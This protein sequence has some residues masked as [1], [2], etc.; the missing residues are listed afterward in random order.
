MPVARREAEIVWEG[1]LARGVG[2]LTSASGALEKLAVTWAS[3]TERAAG[4]TSPEE[5]L[6][7]AHASCFAMALALVLGENKTP[8]ERLGVSAA[9]TLDEVEG[10]PRVTTVELS[11]R[12]QVPGLDAAALERMVGLAADLCP[13]SNA[14]R[15]NVK[16]N[17]RSELVPTVAS[18]TP[19]PGESARPAR[20]TSPW[21]HSRQEAEVEDLVRALR[22]YGVLT[23]ARLLDVCGAAHWSPSAGKRALAR[24][25]ASGQI[26]PL[27]DDLYEIADHRSDEHSAA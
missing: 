16:I 19:E 22:R 2:T 7:S 12:A 20:S 21:P 18:T 27:G 11:I 9:C 25:V 4:K 8:P 13:V 5:L 10:A 24:A 6:A 14:L 23:R 3:R 26:K 1:S 15:G 17:V